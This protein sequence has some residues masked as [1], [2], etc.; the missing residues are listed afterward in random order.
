[1]DDSVRCYDAV[2][3]GV[4]LY[5]LKL[6]SSH[7]STHQKYVPLSDWSVCFQE[8]GF[9]I[10]FKKIS[11]KKLFIKKLKRICEGMHDLDTTTIVIQVKKYFE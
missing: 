4:S 11:G 3:V 10:N 6:Y 9:Q 1:M 2:G 7:A 8:V 5:D